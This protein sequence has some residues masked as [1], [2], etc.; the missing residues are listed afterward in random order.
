MS[1]HDVLRELGIREAPEGHHHGT[2]GRIQIDCPYCSRDERRWRMGLHETRL[3][4]SCWVCG[5]HR[6]V[7]TLA[8]ASGS[9]WRAVKACF[10]A[11]GLEV[12]PQVR[13]TRTGRLVLP[14]GLCKLQS[15]HKEYL[16]GRGFNPKE[17][18]RR[19]EIQGIGIASRLSWRIFI[20]VFLDKRIVSW[21]T[22]AI[23]DKVRKRYHSAAEE[24]ESY[25]GKFLLY[26]EQYA[27]LGITIHEGPTDVWAVGPGAVGVLGLEIT[28][29]QIARMAK[30][31]LRAVCFD[32]EPE[33][34]RRA[35]ALCRELSMHPGET[36]N[37]ILDAKDAAT[38]KKKEIALLRR[39]YLR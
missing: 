30:Y 5:R 27:G 6:L 24:E 13:E 18:V 9:T 15:A 32:N 10:I 7:D 8:E 33:A 37:V 34:Q 12:A 39:S 16:R 22:R 11:E 2:R 28:A 21:T 31:P 20:P 1:L 3:T 19:W 35:E 25:P 23:T 38:A 14:S 17:L 36:H 26:G 4:A 29:Q